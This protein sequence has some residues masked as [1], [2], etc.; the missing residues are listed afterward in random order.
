MDV[1]GAKMIR[2]EFTAEGRITQHLKDVHLMLEQAERAKQ[3]LPLLAVHADVLEAC[4]R[5]GEGDLDN[6]AVI[7]E[8]SRRRG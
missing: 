6:S 2:S 1:K 4:V 5:A 3:Q 8:I 7:K